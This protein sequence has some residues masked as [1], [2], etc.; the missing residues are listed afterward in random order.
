MPKLFVIRSELSPSPLLEPFK[1]LRKK[2]QL[3]LK[4]KVFYWCTAKW[5][6]YLFDKLYVGSLPIVL[7]FYGGARRKTDAVLQQLLTDVYTKINQM[8]KV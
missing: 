5:W 7:F 4:E 1:T 8:L 2:Q 6:F 3:A